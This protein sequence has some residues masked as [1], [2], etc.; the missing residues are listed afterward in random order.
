MLKVSGPILD[1]VVETIT[2]AEAIA[3]RLLERA[4]EQGHVDN[5]KLVVRRRLK[6]HAES[7][8][9]LAGLYA[10]RNLLVQVNGM[11]KVDVVAGRIMGVLTSRGI[12]GP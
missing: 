10:E 3:V 11:G 6:A 12:T 8:V 9:L 4:G 5:I 1:V 7:T 2:D